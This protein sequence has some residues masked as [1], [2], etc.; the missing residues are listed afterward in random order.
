M[1]LK[2]ELELQ[3]VNM[4]LNSLS[5]HPFDEV[6]NLIAKL[7]SQASTQLAEQSKAEAPAEAEAEAEAPAAE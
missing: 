2:L 1:A 3:E 5:K 7:R 6:V 4:V